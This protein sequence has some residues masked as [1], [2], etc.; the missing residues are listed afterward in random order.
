MDVGDVNLTFKRYVESPITLQI[1][2]DYAV[3]VEGK[4][5]DAELMRSYFAAWG[6]REAYATAH[7]G[8]GINPR[9]RWDSLV[10]YDKSDING[11]EIRA[12]SGNFLYSTG[13]NVLAGRATLGHFD[14]PLRNCTIELDGSIVVDAGKL[15][16]LED[17]GVSAEK[18]GF[19]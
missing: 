19:S 14:L 18:G 3:A 16:L 4:G 5:L 1:Q 11:T 8:W 12:F 15:L 7:V 6:D 9:A 13:A 2:N 17:S 10:M